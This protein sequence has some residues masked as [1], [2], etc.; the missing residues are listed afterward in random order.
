[1]PNYKV[2]VRG[3]GG[4]EAHMLPPSENLPIDMITIGQFGSTM[5]DKVAD[6]YIFRHF[7]IEDIIDQINDEIV[8]YWTK[9]QRDEWYEHKRLNYSEPTLDITPYITL[10]QNLALDGDSSIGECGVCYWNEPA[11][12]LE[13]IIKLKDRETILLSDILCVLKNMLNEG[14]TI[15]LFWTACMSSRY[16]IG[17][18]NKVSFNPEKTTDD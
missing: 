3:H 6:Q 7:G 18:K 9:T 12:K 1:M 8:I 13:W 11:G 15:Q 10:S 5:S 2:Y 16:W 14:D 4:E 17:T